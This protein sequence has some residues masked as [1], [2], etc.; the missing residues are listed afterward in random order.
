MVEMHYLI[1]QCLIPHYF[2][3]TQST[4]FLQHPETKIPSPDNLFVFVIL[5]RLKFF[6]NLWVLKPPP[7]FSFVPF[8][9][10]SSLCP[11]SKL[12]LNNATRL[13]ILPLCQYLL[14]SSRN[15]IEASD[16]FPT[17]SLQ[18]QQNWPIITSCVPHMPENLRYQ[19]NNV[20]YYSLQTR[21]VYTPARV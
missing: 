3:R 8:S 15:S 13:F 7:I 11:Y 21:E 4:V 10:A 19:T 2:V 6:K 14:R 16:Y 18:T 5:S 1:W 12:L 9:E 20:Y 17:I